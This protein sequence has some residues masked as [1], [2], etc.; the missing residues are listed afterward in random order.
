VW[1]WHHC[2]IW[3]REISDVAASSIRLAMAAAPVPRSHDSRY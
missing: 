1:W 3:A 2:Q